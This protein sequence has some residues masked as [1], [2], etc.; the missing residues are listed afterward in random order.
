MDLINIAEKFV[1]K[2]ELSN[3]TC[4]HYNI[5]VMDVAKSTKRNGCKYYI[6]HCSSCRKTFVLSSEKIDGEIQ[7]FDVAGGTQVYYPPECV[8]I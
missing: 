7:F 5:S 3:Q 1:E 8:K 2:K 6:L 4:S